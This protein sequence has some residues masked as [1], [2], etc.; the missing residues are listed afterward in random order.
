MKTHVLATLCVSSLLA[1]CG[2]SPRIS[3]AYTKQTTPVQVSAS[4]LAI[5]PMID[6]RPASS[7][8]AHAPGMSS[9]WG[10]A[11]VY[12]AFGSG[13]ID[14][15]AQAG[16]KGTDV[17][18]DGSSGG[19]AGQLDA[20]VRSVVASATGGAPATAA[21]ADLSD[22]RKAAAGRPD[23]VTI[24]PILDQFDAYYMKSED[25]ITGGSSYQQGDY[26]VTK[27]GFASGS[28]VTSFYA[29]M[30]LRLVMLETRGGQIVRQATAYV[31]TSG[32]GTDGLTNAMKAGVEP[33]TTQLAAFVAK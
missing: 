12:F 17:K 5:A 2:S 7:R 19:V 16:D 13:R 6:A 4:N 30:R 18:I 3:A 15:I 33:L 31:A 8:R 25:S 29:N 10:L 32:N 26:Q 27:S 28:A 23:G 9:Y 20:Y 11:L 1:A 22:V 21:A 24:V 14:G